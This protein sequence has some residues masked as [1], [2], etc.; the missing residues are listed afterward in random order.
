MITK[1]GDISNYGLDIGLK[2]KSLAVNKLDNHN[3]GK[4]GPILLKIRNISLPAIHTRIN[5]VFRKKSTNDCTG[6]HEKNYPKNMM[7]KNGGQSKHPDHVAPY[8]FLPH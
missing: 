2:F 5:E 8:L 4:E 1:F 7:R 6:K 3:S